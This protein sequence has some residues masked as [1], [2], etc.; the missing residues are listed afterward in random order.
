MKI[1]FTD[2]V[3]GFTKG[4]VIEFKRSITVLVGNNGSGKS[5]LLD[6]ISG[7]LIN[8]PSILD[9]NLH[10]YKRQE[11][12]KS[13]TITDADYVKVYSYDSVKDAGNTLDTAFDASAYIR[14]G[15]YHTKNKSHGES[16]LFYISKLLGDI[17]NDSEL[18]GRKLLILDE[19]EKGLDLKT[20][21]RISNMLY[22]ISMKHGVDI[23]CASHNLF[24]IANF[25]VYDLNTRETKLGVEYI[26]ELTGYTITKN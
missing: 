9:D 22:N 12:S 3:R 4:E 15:G 25:H 13:I 7:K 21:S 1:E 26:E 16:T 20:Q 6:S 23:I 2:D 8:E 10:N 11:L 17:S 18:K 19:I 14:N 5:T 24:L